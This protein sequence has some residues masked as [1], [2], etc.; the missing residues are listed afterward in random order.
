MVLLTTLSLLK[1][2]IVI[3]NR[4]LSLSILEKSRD[5]QYEDNK[6]DYRDSLDTIFQYKIVEK[7]DS[8]VLMFN[9]DYLKHNTSIAF[10]SDL[11]F[12]DIPELIEYEINSKN[13]PEVIKGKLILK[14]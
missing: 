8:D 12:K 1:I 14:N 7:S 2:V 5:D 4:S 3:T 6:E 13:I 9:I 10:P 11:M